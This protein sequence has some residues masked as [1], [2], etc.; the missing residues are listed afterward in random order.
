M[1]LG[2]GEIIVIVLVILIFFGPKRIPEFSRALG[3]G[4]HEFRKAMRD[5]EDQLEEH[6]RPI[7]E[8]ADEFK[9]DV[10]SAAP[11]EGPSSADKSAESKEDAE[12]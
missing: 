3:R 4:I 10:A 12:S 6:T 5:I 9:K 11:A 1:N 7:R 8:A 2:P